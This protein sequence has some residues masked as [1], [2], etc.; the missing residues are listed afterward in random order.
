MKI[1]L[2]DIGPVLNM[3]HE[4]DVQHITIERKELQI[5]FV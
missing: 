5:H 4:E 1:F 3:F 2:R